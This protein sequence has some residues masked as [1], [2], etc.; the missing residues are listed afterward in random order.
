MR[1][2][3]TYSRLLAVFWLLS[4]LQL[5][6]QPLPTGMPVLEESYRRAQLL[7]LA[8]STLSFMLRPMH[9]LATERISDSYG[10]HE[11]FPAA[12]SIKGAN[13][14][15]SFLKGHGKV[16]VLPSFIQSQH[17]SKAPYGW[18]DGAMISN[19]GIQ[20]LFIGG[21]FAKLGPIQLQLRPEFL[22]AQNAD[23]E[24]FPAAYSPELWQSRLLDWSTADPPERFGTT[25][26][27]RLMIGQSFLAL[28]VEPISLGISGESVGW[29]PGQFN[30]LILGSNARGFEHLF[31]R[32]V[33]PV[34]IFLGHM[35]LN[36][37]GGRLRP[38]DVNGSYGSYG[39]LDKPKDNRYVSGLNM[40]FAPRWLTGLHL[41]FSRTFQ[42]YYQDLGSGLNDYFP[43]LDGFQKENVGFDEDLKNRSQQASV[44]FRWVFQKAHAEAYFEFGKRDHAL[45]WR[46]FTMSPEHARAFI[47]GFQ[48]LFYINQSDLVQLRFEMTQTEQAV[49]RL[50]RDVNSGGGQSWGSHYPVRSGFSH[51]GQQ[52]GN[53]VGP[54]NNAQTLEIAWVKDIRKLGV[55]FERLE[56]QM[57]FFNRAF[58]DGSSARPWVD[59]ST[60]LIGHWRFNRLVANARVQFI[61][62]LNYQW[63]QNVIYPGGQNARGVDRFNLHSYMGLTY[64]F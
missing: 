46:D 25:S 6:G 5:H 2:L 21:A 61:R 41:G 48:K 11:L 14:S 17:N 33:S 37:L 54:G 64:L 18:N 49:N 58:R 39:V 8:D 4:R 63:Q 20:S 53:G 13:L 3:K 27:S 12:D 60:G 51:Y 43:L 24:G 15:R 52:L 55:M 40:I 16:L 38:P 1:E 44:S 26:Y 28:N 59:V 56:H 32:T 19:R 42:V 23:F 36:I 47:L 50:V 29:G 7:G 22:F 31:L 62:S 34:N 57:D 10:L 9:P 35:E 30:S 45:N